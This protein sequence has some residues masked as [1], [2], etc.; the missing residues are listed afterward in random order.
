MRNEDFEFPVVSATVA[1]MLTVTTV[2][3]S[4]PWRNASEF[5]ERGKV[6]GSGI[7]H[8]VSE[9]GICYQHPIDSDHAGASL[10]VFRN[11]NRGD[12]ALDLHP[13]QTVGVILECRP[14]PEVGAGSAQAGPCLQLFASLNCQRQGG[15]IVHNCCSRLH[16]AASYSNPSRSGCF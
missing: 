5:G 16:P 13:R 8:L 3:P 15:G 2:L 7:F 1:P 4:S 14:S 11:K 6:S 12:R 10:F 9:S